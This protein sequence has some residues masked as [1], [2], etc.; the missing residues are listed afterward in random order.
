MHRRLYTSLG[1]TVSRRNLQPQQNILPFAHLFANFSADDKHDKHKVAS[2]CPPTTRYTP[3][4]SRHFTTTRRSENV[5]V[6]LGLAGVA[7]SLQVVKYGL[8]AY[9]EWQSSPP[10]TDSDSSSDSDSDSSSD[11]SSP[12]SSK[13]KASKKNIFEDINIPFFT[14]GDAAKKFYEGPFEDDMTRQEAA[15]ILGVR[16]S[17]S[18]KRIRDAHRKILILNHPDTGGSTYLSSKINEAKELLLKGK[19]KDKD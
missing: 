15:L 17:A 10:A 8:E 12:S 7:V 16:E 4:I 18:T 19:G 6:A 9:D 5:T 1:R 14:P 2:P 3:V 11:P 13:S